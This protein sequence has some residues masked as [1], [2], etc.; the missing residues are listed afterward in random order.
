MKGLSPQTTLSDI[1]KYFA[2]QKVEIVYRVSERVAAVQL[3]SAKAVKTALAKSGTVLPVVRTGTLAFAGD[4]LEVV[5]A[6]D[7]T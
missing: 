6:T 5:R 3:C 7:N 4:L 2:D 1:S